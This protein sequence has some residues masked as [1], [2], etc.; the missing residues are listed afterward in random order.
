M[1]IRDSYQGTAT[2]DDVFKASRN[3]DGSPAKSYNDT[4]A[5]AYANFY[6]GLYFEMRGDVVKAAEYLKA[7]ADLENPDYMGKLMVMH[8]EL[9]SK[10]V[11][12]PQQIP[13]FIH[14]VVSSNS[15]TGNGI[16]KIVQGGWQLSQGHLTGSNPLFKSDIVVNLL[17]A[18]DAGIRAFDCGDIYT[19][20]EELYG[21]FIKALCLRGMRDTDVRILTKFVPD[22]DVIQARQVDK[23][24]VRPV[25]RRSLN[26]LGVSRLSLVQFHWWDYD[27]PG[28]CAALDA[29]HDLVKEGAIESIGLTNF[30][31]KHTKE[32]IEAGIPI[33]SVQVPA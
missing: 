3:P 18:Y 30:D 17:R 26:R 10:M 2:V 32:V 16:G 29:L 13:S 22:L 20:V 27:I 11:P 8:F 9:F 6:A 1:C 12:P 21:V 33:V 14:L 5:L 15:Q 7:A 19:G 28:Y 25:I 23:T 24:Y 31:A 4:N